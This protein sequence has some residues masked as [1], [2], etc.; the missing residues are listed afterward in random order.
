[1]ATFGFAKLKISE[2]F[3]MV[4]RL[5]CAAID[6]ELQRL[7]V[8]SIAMDAFFQFTWNNFLHTTVEQI[9]GGVLEGDNVA[10]QCSLVTQTKLLERIVEADRENTEEQAR[11]RGYRRGFMGHLTAI[12]LRLQAAAARAPELDALLNADEAWLDY[13]N[14]SLAQLRAAE[15]KPLGGH[16][17]MGG[18]GESSDEDE[19]ELDDDGDSIFD[20]YQLGF[21]TDDFADD[22]SDDEDGDG[23][24][25]FSNEF[26]G[27]TPGGTSFEMYEDGGDGS[28]EEGD[29]PVTDAAPDVDPAADVAELVAN[30]E[31]AAG[32]DNADVVVV[33]EGDDDNAEADDGAQK[34]YAAAAASAVEAN[35]TTTADDN[36]DDNGGDTEEKPSD[37]PTDE[38]EKAD[39]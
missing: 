12:A 15:S 31:Q 30:V 22:D 24:L 5:N 19:E 7:D 1:M 38:E 20:R 14:G 36:G 17:P 6:A 21:G 18:P 2:F 13:V 16:R 8:F 35:D 37:T 25:D 10:L 39:E 29:W 4:V 34:S 27:A 23:A 9:V 28:G 32:D 11:P 3:A 26:V 33:Q